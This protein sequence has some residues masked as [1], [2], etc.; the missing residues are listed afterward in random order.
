M[1]RNKDREFIF[2]A[3]VEGDGKTTF[4]EV[5]APLMIMWD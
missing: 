2:N 5:D 3:V 1:E 4:A